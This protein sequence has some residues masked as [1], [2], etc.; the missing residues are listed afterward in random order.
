M[1]I[2]KKNIEYIEIEYNNVFSFS[3]ITDGKIYAD[4][5]TGIIKENILYYPSVLPNVTKYH[6][7]EYSDE[8][9]VSLEASVIITGQEAG[10]RP[11]INMIA[12]KQLPGDDIQ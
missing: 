1:G 9:S 2:L 7:V 8:K 11:S 12:L 5:K 3:I 10:K 4:N 6:I